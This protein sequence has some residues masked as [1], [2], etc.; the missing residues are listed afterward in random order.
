M[1]KVLKEKLKISRLFC[2]V[3]G[4]SEKTCSL[5]SWAIGEQSQEVKCTT[6]YKL[7]C[8]LGIDPYCIDHG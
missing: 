8:L 6:C 4:I 2:K 5:G 3:Y 1:D 7:H